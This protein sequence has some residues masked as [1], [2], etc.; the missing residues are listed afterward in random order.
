MSKF[1]SRTIVALSVALALA[2]GSASATNGYFTHGIGTKSKSMA[3]SGS[4]D[5]QEL[6][7]MATNPAGLAFL[8]QSIDAGLGIVSPRREYRTS[9]SQLKGNCFTPPGGTQPFCPFTIGPNNITS[10]NEYFFIPYVA[11]NWKLDEQSSLGAAFYA[12]GGMNTQ[13]QGGTAS[14]DPDGAMGPAPAM[15]FKGTYGGGFTGGNGDAG[16]DL[17]QGF[18]NLTYAWKTADD[19]FALGASAI[20]ALQRFQARGVAAFSP[21]TKT[22]IESYMTTGQPTMPTHLSGN[23][24]DM[25]YGYGGSVGALWN[26][27]KWLSLAAAYTSKMSMSEFSDYSDLYAEHGKFDIPS[28][29]TYGLTIRPTDAFTFNFD[30]QSIWYSDTPSVSNPIDNLFTCPA[31]GGTNLEGCLG[32]KQGAGFGWRD[33]SVYKFGGS[34]KYSD[35][36][37]FRAGY[38]FPDSQPIPKNQ[39]EFNILAP[40]VVEE[41]FTVGFTRTMSDG[42]ELSLSFMYAPDYSLKGQNNFDPTQTIE[43]SMNQFELEMSYSWKR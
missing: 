1:S 30:Y 26:A 8:P 4:A 13:W 21:Y 22:Y 32:G 34:W 12:R 3:G 19:Q 33:M 6:L 10:E 37:T 42:D 17:M 7:E 18:L 9:D 38:S 25:S 43:F 28:S 11:M 39:M 23:G 14:F 27:T 29:A 36:W 24:H 41:H 40:G 5:P 16:V 20:F 31:V 15:T 2:A 35:Q